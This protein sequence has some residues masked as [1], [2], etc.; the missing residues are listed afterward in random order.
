MPGVAWSFSKKGYLRRQR[1]F[2]A[3]DTSASLAGKQLAVTGANGGIGFAVASAW[4]KKNADIWMLCRSRERGEAAREKLAT[5]GTG[6]VHLAIVD[7]AKPETIDA[8][9]R[10]AAPPVL[11]G[12]VHNAGALVHERRDV[13]QDIEETCACHV[14]GPQRLTRALLPALERAAEARVVYVAS[15][16]MYAERLVVDYL[17]HPPSPF[18][19]V[20]AYARAKRAQVVLTERWSQETDRVQFYAMHP[21]WVDT[22]GV[23]DALPRFYRATKRWLRTPAQGAD[24][25]IWLTS[26]PRVPLTSGAFVFDRQAAPRHLLPGTRAN[27]S[28]RTKLWDAVETLASAP[29]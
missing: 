24:T 20:R 7:L 26:A 16:G 5:L 22:P 18:D 15:G 25:A 12:L 4:A 11:D 19:G 23:R 10:S 13:A 8:F 2:D 29:C 1:S 6:Q 9:A 27:T 21:G 28:E 17:L 14:V 3:S